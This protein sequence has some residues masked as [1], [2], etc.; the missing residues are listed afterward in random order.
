MLMTFVQKVKEEQAII[1]EG[2]MRRPALQIPAEMGRVAGL[3][4][5]LDRALEILDECF[6]EQ[7][8]KEQNS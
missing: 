5:G 3:W 1:A 7:R 2:G 4:Q 8:D 6:R